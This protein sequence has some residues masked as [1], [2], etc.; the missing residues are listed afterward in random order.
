MRKKGTNAITALAF[1]SI[2]AT[3]AGAATEYDFDFHAYPNPFFPGRDKAA[4]YYDLPSSGSVSIYVYD[5]EGALVRTVRENYPQVYGQH[6][7]ELEWNGSN[8]SR[9]YVDPGP[10]VVVLEVNIAREIYRDT[11]VAIVNR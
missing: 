6:D 8:D 1:V 10:Y 3:A 5:L 7:G 4:F 11:F 2:L 9:E